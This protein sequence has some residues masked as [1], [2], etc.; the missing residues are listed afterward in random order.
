MGVMRKTKNS[1]DA[2]CGFFP[3]EGS[4]S[5]SWMTLRTLRPSPFLSCETSILKG[6]ISSLESSVTLPLIYSVN[7]SNVLI[8]S[9]LFKVWEVNNSVRLLISPEAVPVAVSH[10]Q[11]T[12]IISSCTDVVMALWC[13]KM[14][15]KLTVNNS[16]PQMSNNHQRGSKYARSLREQQQEGLRSKLLH[17]WEVEKAMVQKFSQ[18]FCYSCVCG[19]CLVSLW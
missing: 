1:E 12:V 10:T 9:H 7:M 5:F 16:N 8:I 17:T 2:A 14:I 13:S 6:L 18:G 19:V 15:L 3:L 4:G 11:Y